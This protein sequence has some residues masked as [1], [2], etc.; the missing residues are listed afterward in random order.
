MSYPKAEV[1]TSK[2]AILV[3]DGDESLCE[4]A[5]SL[6]RER[7]FRAESCA[8]VAAALER[9]AQEQFELIVVEARMADKSG[10]H[11]LDQ[12]KV[13]GRGEDVIVVSCCAAIEQGVDAMRRG[14]ADYL[15]KPFQLGEFAHAVDK[16]LARRHERLRSA[17]GSA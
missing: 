4:T 15:A 6:F 7:G 17:C 5:K 9:L 3:V 12:V 10:L 11:L 1:Q 8:S 14:A 16:A 13:R 2:D